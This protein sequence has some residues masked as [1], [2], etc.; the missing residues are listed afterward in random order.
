[1]QLRKTPLFYEETAEDN[2]SELES[3]VVMI[4]EI[5]KFIDNKMKQ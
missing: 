4:S 2:T 5:I 1:M 3:M